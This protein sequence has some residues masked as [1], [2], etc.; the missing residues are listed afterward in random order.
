M[1]YDPAANLSRLSEFWISR[2]SAKQRAGRAGRT[3]PGEVSRSRELN[4]HPPHLLSQ[5]TPARNI[6]CYRLYSK[7]EYTRLNEFP[8]PEILRMPL[9][10]TLLQIR[11]YG[12][13]DP[14]RFEFIERPSEGA[15]GFSVGRLQDLGALERS[16]GEGITALGRVLAV[17]PLDVVLGKMLVLGSVSV[18]MSE[19]AVDC[20]AQ[21]LWA[22]K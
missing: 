18:D 22:F 11:A 4:L 5:Q 21:C 6:Q 1:G 12:L 8:V 20:A 13:G 15:V 14:R 3:G 19:L 9:E 17:L 16:V 7:K 2:S 10:P